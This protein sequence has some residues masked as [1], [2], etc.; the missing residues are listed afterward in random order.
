M[1]ILLVEDDNRS[2]STTVLEAE[3]HRLRWGLGLGGVVALGLTAIGG[4]W[5]TQESLKPVVQNLEQLK[6]FTADASHELRSPLT[7]VQASVAVMQTHPE[8]VHPSDVK[9]LDA[10]ASASKQMSCLVEDLLLLARIDS[11]QTNCW[12]WIPIAIDEILEA[13]LK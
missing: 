12:E 2:E 1:K 8:R 9:K 10:I 4:V 6:Q 13:L 11:Q 3:L 5:L 7:A